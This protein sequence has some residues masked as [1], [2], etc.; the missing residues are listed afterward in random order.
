MYT[1][2]F[3]IANDVGRVR[4]RTTKPSLPCELRMQLRMFPLSLLCCFLPVQPVE[5]EDN[6]NSDDQRL[7]LQETGVGRCF[8]AAINKNV[9]NRKGN[10]R[11]RY[12]CDQVRDA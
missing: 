9:V 2:F 11:Q 10:D 5:L 1:L 7:A 6:R 12:R 4:T 8:D 3:A